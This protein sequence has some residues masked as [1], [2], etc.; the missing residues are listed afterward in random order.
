MITPYS[1]IRKVED[2]K[3]LLEENNEFVFTLCDNILFVVKRLLDPIEDSLI[4][5]ERNDAVI[6]GLFAKQYYL[7]NSFIT[8]CKTNKDY[9]CFIFQRVIYET[10][11]K[12]SY[13]IHHEKEELEK[14]RLRSYKD[15]FDFYQKHVSNNNGIEAVRNKKFLDDLF[16]DGFTLDDAKSSQKAFGG[17]NMRQL[18]KEEED[19]DEEK[20]LYNAL[21][22]IGSD[23]IHS[24]W[25]EIRQ[26]Y[27]Q[28]TPSKNYV[29]YLEKERTIHY[30]YIIGMVQILLDSTHKYYNWLEKIDEIE[31]QTK[32]IMIL[33]EEF[34]RIVK[35]IT[36]D[37]IKTYEE[38]T[39]KFMYE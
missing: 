27:L 25:G 23:S 3:P 7:F 1:S 16:D 30:R 13:L 17:K 35:L 21:Y 11:I 24:D 8:S 19:N 12:M 10:F 22:S 31:V 26:L 34:E 18:I 29:C 32:S 15:R 6:V 36:S 20:C 2:I 5:F 39:E 33:L 9:E 14:Y 38:D 37:V 28:K 4:E